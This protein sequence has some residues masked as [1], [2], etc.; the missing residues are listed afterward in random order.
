[1][2]YYLLY[3]FYKVTLT[4]YKYAQIYNVSALFGYSHLNT[5]VL[6]VFFGIM[7]ISIGLDRQV[8]G[9][10]MLATMDFHVTHV[11]KHFTLDFCCDLLLSAMS[12]NGIHT[13]TLFNDFSNLQSS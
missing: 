2:L 12:H 6:N 10:F 11:S 4:V 5:P 7:L 3:C 13:Y 1:M 8:K 9:I